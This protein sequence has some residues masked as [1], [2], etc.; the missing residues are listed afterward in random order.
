MRLRRVAAANANPREFLDGANRAFGHWGDE[1]MFA[2]AFRNDA[3]ILFLDDEQGHA[4]A[5]SGIV[6]R[7]LRGGHP[8]A[9][10][11]GSWTSVE[12]RGRGAFSRMID[13]TCE[14]ARERG[15]VVL[16]FGRTENASRRRFD[17]RGTIY[18][19]FYCRSVIPSRITALVDDLM[20]NDG[21]QWDAGALASVLG[22]RT[23]EA[24]APHREPFR[25]R[26]IRSVSEGSGRVGTRIAAAPPPR[27]LAP[28]R[29]DTFPSSFEYSPEEWRAQFL[30]RPGAQIE[31]IGAAIVE[32]TDDFD[33]VHAV[34]D[35]ASLP[36]LAARAHAAGRRLFWYA[37][38]HPTLECEWTDGFIVAIPELPFSDFVFQN[39][40]RM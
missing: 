28:A 27:P 21:S 38:S 34:S 22:A 2:W 37:T 19:A 6:Y 5:A 20:T 40:D 36:Q 12:S 4:I 1:A 11:T 16:A 14:I 33:R 39:G 30:E 17:S 31:Y 24:P 32:H 25:H 3:E 18:P 29:G 15:A 8:A 35:P 9:I 26:V 13:A 7:T 23:G 10:I